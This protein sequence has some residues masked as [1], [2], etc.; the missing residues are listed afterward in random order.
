M[1]APSTRFYKSLPNWKVARHSLV[2]DTLSAGK[3][4]VLVFKVS[5]LS[6]FLSLNLICLF[7]KQCMAFEVLF[8]TYF[9]QPHTSTHN[10]AMLSVTHTPTPNHATPLVTHS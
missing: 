7:G 2:R 8:V 3:R 4:V 1:A 6:L 5:S 9:G 10:H